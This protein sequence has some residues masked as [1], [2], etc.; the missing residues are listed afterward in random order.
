MGTQ[1]DVYVINAEDI[2]D[3]YAAGAQHRPAGDRHRVRPGG[4]REARVPGPAERGLPDERPGLH[5]LDPLA[6]CVGR[7]A[8]LQRAAEAGTAALP[9]G[10]PRRGRALVGGEALARAEGGGVPLR[11]ERVG[12]LRLSGRR[13]FP[14]RISSCSTTWR[15]PIIRRRW[16]RAP[17]GIPP[18]GSFGS[19]VPGGSGVGPAPE[20]P[21]LG[22][23][24]FFLFCL[25][26][27]IYVATL[28]AVSP[29]LHFAAGLDLNPLTA[30][31]ASLAGVGVLFL[32]AV[33]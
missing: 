12:D 28:L 2:L 3:D 33:A 17:R 23:A 11:R 1:E 25:L 24:L 5:R 15:R 20:R 13:R 30:R 32:G 27:G 22:K 4:G 8:G 6:L 14:D 29:F 19:C 31:P 9:D 18:A 10:S 7:R 16:T 26:G 21:S